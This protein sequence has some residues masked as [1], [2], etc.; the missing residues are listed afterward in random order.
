V[1]GDMLSN[2]L[3]EV[4]E[5][6]KEKNVILDEISMSEDTPDDVSYDLIAKVIYGNDSLGQPILGYKENIEAFTREDLIAY[7]KKHYTPDNLVI[8]IA[9]SFEESEVINAL[10]ESL[11]LNAESKIQ[12]PFTQGFNSEND[13]IFRDIEQV[14]LEM[15]FEGYP[16]H[17][18]KLFP[19]AAFNAVLGASVSSRLFQTIRE[20]HGL[21]YAINSYITQYESTGLFNLYASMY[22]K[23]VIK[24]AELIAEILVDLKKNGIT[25]EELNRVKEQLKGSYILDLEGSESYMN[26]IGKG[27]L[28]N[29]RIYT[30]DEIENN[31][32]NLTLEYVNGIVKE[33]LSQSPAFSL[34][35]KVDDQLFDEVKK[36]MELI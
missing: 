25:L 7:M 29:K 9:G 24:V 6:N 23:N 21:T 1:I 30:V 33:V 28:F 3:L 19:L 14:H 35:G 27:K 17:S 10:N 32:N 13:F 31:I 2:P 11:T 4:E 5:I 18:E 20:N 22:H 16:Y 36:I 8:S 34:V 15:A 12:V 26:L